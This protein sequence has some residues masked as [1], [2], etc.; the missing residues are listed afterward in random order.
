M[1]TNSTNNMSSF[2]RPDLKKVDLSVFTIQKLKTK[3]SLPTWKKWVAHC[4][5]V[6]HHRQGKPTS[7]TGKTTEKIGLAK[8]SPI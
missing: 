7:K 3:D 5:D 2:G 6:T 8:A 4:K 1:K